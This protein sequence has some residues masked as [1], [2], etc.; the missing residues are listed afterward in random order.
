MRDTGKCA[1]GNIG[2]AG[3]L[4]ES[5]AWSTGEMRFLGESTCLGAVVR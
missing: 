5:R 1:L 4:S 2:A 3:Q